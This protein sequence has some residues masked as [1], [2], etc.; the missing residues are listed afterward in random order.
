MALFYLVL[1]TECFFKYYIILGLL[2]DRYFV[3]LYCY[4]CFDAQKCLRGLFEINI[5]VF[6]I[7]V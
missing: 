1:P 4:I 5:V 6:E 7:A 2:S 3:F